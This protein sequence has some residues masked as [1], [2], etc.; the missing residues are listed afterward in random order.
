MALS[1][2]KRART[3]PA[4][5]S[6]L[7]PLSK[8]YRASELAKALEQGDERRNGQC[9]QQLAMSSDEELWTFLRRI[10]RNLKNDPDQPNKPVMPAG[11]VLECLHFVI[12]SLTHRPLPQL[13]T[14]V[15]AALV[16]TTSSDFQTLRI[17]VRN[18]I[19]NLK[20]G[21]QMAQVFALKLL[22]AFLEDQ[23]SATWKHPV[24][25][26]LIVDEI[27]PTNCLDLILEALAQ[28]TQNVQHYALRVLMALT[29]YFG[30]DM[31]EKDALWTVAARIGSLH[32]LLTREMRLPERQREKTWSG[33]LHI[34]MLAGSLVRRLVQIAETS[35]ATKLRQFG[36][37]VAFSTILKV[38]P[39]VVWE[40]TQ[41]KS[42]IQGIDRL[43]TGLSSVVSKIA[44]VSIEATDR[45]RSDSGFTECYHFV[46]LKYATIM[47]STPQVLLSD[48]L[49]AK[50]PASPNQRGDSMVALQDT[51]HAISRIVVSVYDAKSTVRLSTTVIEQ[52]LVDTLNFL[53]VMLWHPIV[54]EDFDFMSQK[55]RIPDDAITTLEEAMKPSFGV[56]VQKKPNVIKTMLDILFRYLQLVYK[57]RMKELCIP[58]AICLRHIAVVVAM[59]PYEAYESILSRA[60]QLAALLLYYPEGIK[61]LSENTSSSANA[62]FWHPIIEQA[63]AALRE[64]IE[65]DINSVVDVAVRSKTIARGKRALQSLL[66]A[67]RV[68]EACPKIVEAGVLTIIDPFYPPRQPQYMDLKD[69]QLL[70]SLMAEILYQ[71]AKDMALVRGKLRQEHQAI[72]CILH[73]LCQSI[74]KAQQQ[75]TSKQELE[76]LQRSCL[77]VVTAFRFDRTGLQDWVRY[78]MNEELMGYIE[79]FSEAAISNQSELSVTPILLKLLFPIAPDEQGIQYKMQ[80]RKLSEVTTQSQPILLEALLAL[81]PLSLLPTSLRQIM[82]YPKALRWLSQLLIAGKAAVLE[83]EG[84]ASTSAEEATTSSIIQNNTIV[85]QVL[86]QVAETDQVACLSDMASDTEEQQQQ[87]QSSS[88]AEPSYPSSDRITTIWVQVLYQ[89]LI[90]AISFKD[91][92]QW[93]VIQDLY[94]DL[95]GPWLLSGNL[96]D[97]PM[98]SL[99]AAF[100]SKA[101]TETLQDLL[102][103]FNYAKHN[104]EAIRLM[105]FTSVAICYAI[106]PA[107]L[108]TQILDLNEEDHLNSSSVFGVLCRMLFCDLEPLDDVMDSANEQ[109]QETFQRR[110]AA[111]QAVQILMLDM[112]PWQHELK[113]DQL[114]II[115]IPPAADESPEV[116]FLSTEDM[117]TP[118]QASKE[119][120]SS[121]SETFRALLSDQYREATQDTIMLRGVNGD[122][123]TALV[124]AIQ[125]A[126]HPEPTIVLSDMAWRTVV[127]LLLISDRYVVDSVTRACQRWMLERFADPTPPDDTLEGA[128]LTYRLCRDPTSILP[129]TA[130]P[131]SMLTLAALKTILTHMVRVTQTEEFSSMVEGIGGIE[132]INEIDSFCSAMG[133]LLGGQ[134]V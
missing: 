71:L 104:D 108:R 105:E 73:I 133:L 74:R 18:S 46:L 20:T 134:A 52:L 60:Q 77:Q 37:S 43:M 38:W 1:P 84:E 99:I 49:P 130:W 58:A 30:K 95:F 79:Q 51:L 45:I 6:V 120:L 13:D 40:G 90:R 33:K 11:K 119:L 125:R 28:D 92:L 29:N 32:D 39:V 128:M 34:S 21:S 131:H 41:G 89:C 91:S 98:A 57:P 15:S 54:P 70:C 16:P 10:L 44:T 17:C 48:E 14:T 107:P 83:T 80:P 82:V 123:L 68:S 27:R 96:R 26:K 63:K 61:S 85:N 118:V 31:V 62:I 111:G 35:N 42:E 53:V 109:D 78:P 124:D 3:D 87:Q 103:F 93:F 56:Y 81:E 69:G 113:I 121:A 132:H 86:E 25:I 116:V 23:K 110:T 100:R 112:D 47:Q 59:E 24:P 67:A 50:R 101:R 7:T 122:D 114:P 64:L 55:E 115:P 94:T 76:R 66:R 12:T 5:E 126:Q 65:Y 36:S 19:Q 129:D 102:R 88:T 127:G 117:V 9:R 72:P 4:H 8:P 2:R 106:P 75:T 22:C 97:E